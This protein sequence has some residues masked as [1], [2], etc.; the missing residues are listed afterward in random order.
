LQNVFCS[1]F[2]LPSLRNTRKSDKSKQKVE[3]KLTSKILS[4]LWILFRHGFLQKYF[5]GVLELPLPRNAQKRDDV[6]KKIQEKK[7]GRWVGWNWDLAN[8]WGGGGRFSFGGPSAYGLWPRASSSSFWVL[9][10]LR[11]KGIRAMVQTVSTGNPAL[12]RRLGLCV[13]EHARRRKRA[14]RKHRPN[15]MHL[16]ARKSRGGRVERISGCTTRV[17]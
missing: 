7:V 16:G 1:V 9:R 2:E 17:P 12:V 6:L 10:L 14:P 4:I 3:E 11:G 5:D 8:L 13:L 15:P